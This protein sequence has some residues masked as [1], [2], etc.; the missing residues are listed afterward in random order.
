MTTGAGAYVFVGA[1]AEIAIFH[2]TAGCIGRT[3]GHLVGALVFRFFGS[4]RNWDD[5]CRFFGLDATTLG[6]VTLGVFG[7]AVFIIRAA[8]SLSTTQNKQV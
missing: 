1:A 7:T 8:D 3:G 2:L 4:L 5:G 6:K